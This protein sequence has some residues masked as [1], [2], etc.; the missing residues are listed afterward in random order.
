[1]DEVFKF[2]YSLDFS[3]SSSILKEKIHHTFKNIKW[4]FYV[5]QQT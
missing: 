3:R 4:S 5:K 2:S 1:M